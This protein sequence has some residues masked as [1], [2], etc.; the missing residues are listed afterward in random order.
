MKKLL[1]I[2]SL[3][4]VLA[5]AGCDSD[6]TS[7]GGGSTSTAYFPLTK[8]SWW[9]YERSGATYTMITTDVSTYN[10]KQYTSWV[11][12]SDSS[13]NTYAVSGSKIYQ[14]TPDS[15]LLGLIEFVYADLAAGATWNSD[16]T[17]LFGRVKTSGKTVETGISHTVLSKTFTDVIHVELD[18]EAEAFGF[19]TKKKENIYFAKGVGIVEIL[20]DGIS[21]DRIT[22]YLIK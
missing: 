3:L 19:T 5:S 10:G 21:T 13:G 8:G 6:S 14:L 4:V 18:I 15:T 16:I 12:Q 9:K 22:D 20:T 1:I 17:N 7:P 11:D 2:F